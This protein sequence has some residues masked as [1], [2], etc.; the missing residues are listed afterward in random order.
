MARSFGVT[1]NAVRTLGDMG[2]RDSDQLLGL[3]RQGAIAEH[4]IA[5]S[6]ERSSDLRRE[7][8][9]L[10]SQHLARFWIDRLGYGTSLVLMSLVLGGS[11]PD[12]RQHHRQ[13]NREGGG[14]NTT[15][16]DRSL[17]L[18]RPGGGPGLEASTCW[19]DTCLEHDHVSFHR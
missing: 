5:E 6:A 13:E 3:T 19:I 7:G 18:E 1:L 8:L 16:F 4:N 12:V 17:A 10:V 15:A 14:Q 11:P 9:S 2:D